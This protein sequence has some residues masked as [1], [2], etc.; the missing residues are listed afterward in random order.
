MR[1]VKY[2]FLVVAIAMISFSCK[3]ESQPETKTID[4]ASKTEAE[5]VLNPD[6][7][8]TDA[9]FEIEG[10]KCA[11]GC[12]KV[13][14][15]NI[16][17]MDGVKEVKVDFETKTATVSFD[18]QLASQQKISATVVNTSD[19]YSVTSWNGKTITE[20]TEESNE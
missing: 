13:I 17:K 12:A 5:K 1:T 18:E 2:T 15:K 14:E 8:Y 10:M 11:M 3:N 6:A 20:K 4:V 9:T 7:I 19:T 16:A